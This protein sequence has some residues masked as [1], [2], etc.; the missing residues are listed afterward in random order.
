MHSGG[1]WVFFLD[2]GSDLGDWTGGDWRYRATVFGR[3]VDAPERAVVGG[4]FLVVSSR[5]G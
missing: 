5:S 4:A 2:G 1:M 3:S